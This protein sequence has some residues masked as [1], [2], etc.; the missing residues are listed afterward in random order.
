MWNAWKGYRLEQSLI[1]KRR[2]KES[3]QKALCECGRIIL[4]WILRNC[5]RMYFD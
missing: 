2:R 5:I 4:K 3:I 1:G